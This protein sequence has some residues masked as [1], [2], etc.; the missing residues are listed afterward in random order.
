MWW[1]RLMSK[2]QLQSSPF[3][4]AVCSSAD[5]ACMAASARCVCLLSLV[6]CLLSPVSCLLSHVSCLLSPVSCLLSPVSS[7]AGRLS[8]RLSRYLSVFSFYFLLVSLPVSMSRFL[9]VSP[10]KHFSALTDHVLSL[11]CIRLPSECRRD[12]REVCK[13]RD[14]FAKGR[15]TKLEGMHFLTCMPIISLLFSLSVCLPGRALVV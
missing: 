3:R 8:I 10:I 4:M 14:Q 2:A 12:S 13:G 11:K 1:W 9:V 15:E 7:S 6:S 5:G